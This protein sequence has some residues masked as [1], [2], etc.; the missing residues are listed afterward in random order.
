M[1]ESG[2]GFEMKKLGDSRQRSFSATF[3]TDWKV[4]TIA[5]SFLYISTYNQEINYY[6]LIIKNS[7]RILK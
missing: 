7:R 3:S 6:T 1:V 2:Y 5:V 4:S